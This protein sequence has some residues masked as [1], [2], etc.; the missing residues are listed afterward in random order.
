MIKKVLL[1]L[2][3]ALGLTMSAF[4]SSCAMGGR[5][6]MGA[7]YAAVAPQSVQILFQAPAWPANQI[8]IVSSL[9]AQVASDA[10]VYK[11]LQSQAARLGADAVL[12]ISSEQKQGPA[13]ATY[14]AFG[15]ANLYGNENF[16]TG[17]ATY[18][19]TGFAVGPQSIGLSVRGIA[20]KRI[21]AKNAAHG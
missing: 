2:T 15:S 17:N 16:V 14:N 9:G 20:L 7:N 11:E 8:G 21:S 13:I 18:Q 19:A 5:V 1:T 10:T 3:T 12:V 4:L 6:A